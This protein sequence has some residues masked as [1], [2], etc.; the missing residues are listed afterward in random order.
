LREEA[1]RH[2]FVCKSFTLSPILISIALLERLQIQEWFPYL[3]RK[4]AGGR[5]GM[6]SD[7]FFCERLFIPISLRKNVAPKKIIREQ[8]FNFWPICI[9]KE[10]NVW[11]IHNY[12]KTKIAN[13]IKIG[14]KIKNWQAKVTDSLF[15]QFAFPWVSDSPLGCTRVRA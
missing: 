15:A 10:G 1:L 7:D 6:R 11:G 2:L 3:K 4:F 8:Y 13:D 12:S 14:L 5:G 9:S